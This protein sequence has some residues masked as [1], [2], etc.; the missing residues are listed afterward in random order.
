MRD[1]NKFFEED[2]SKMI[3]NSYIDYI[4]VSAYFHPHR[5]RNE[6]V[7]K[8][9]ACENCETRYLLHGTMIDPISYILTNEFKYPRRSFYGLGIYFTD[10]IDYVSFIVG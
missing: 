1:F 6:F 10:M 2:F 5:R 7:E 4:L 9:N 8:L 3:E